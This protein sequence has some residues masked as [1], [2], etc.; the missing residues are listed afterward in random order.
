MDAMIGDILR[1]PALRPTP[2]TSR[3]ALPASVAST[4]VAPPVDAAQIDGAGLGAVAPTETVAPTEG[5]WAE[6]AS[7][8]LLASSAAVGG[9]LGGTLSAQ[10]RTDLGHLTQALVS[11][12]VTFFRERTLHLGNADRFEQADAAQVVQDAAEKGSRRLPLFAQSGDGMLIPVRDFDALRTLDAVAGTG[13]V[14]KL[15]HPAMASVLRNAEAVHFLVRDGREVPAWQAYQILS[16]AEPLAAGVT[17]S[18]DRAS[19]ALSS[20]ADLLVYAALEGVVEPHGLAREVREARDAGMSFLTR[21]REPEEMSA[22]DACG[23]LSRGRIAVG[24]VGVPLAECD[25]AGFAATRETLAPW[26][27]LYH[28]VLLPSGREDRTL[29][30]MVARLASSAPDR[31]DGDAKQMLS[32]ADAVQ[33]STPEYQFDE[34]LRD[35]LDWLAQRGPKLDRPE[36]QMPVVLRW[37]EACGARD[38]RQA[39]DFAWDTLSVAHPAP[40]DYAATLGQF[41]AL[42]SSL[43][44]VKAAQAALQV[45]S[46]P[47]GDASA[48][49]RLQAYERLLALHPPTDAG[50]FRSTENLRE[51]ADAAAADYLSVMASRSPLEG[52]VDQFERLHRALDT[53]KQADQTRTTFDFIE[54][55]LAGGTFGDASR[56]TVTTRFME[57]LAQTGDA[58]RARVLAMAPAGARGGTIERSD[59]TVVIGGIRVPRRM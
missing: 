27:K 35:T 58:E 59:D 52:A 39:A 20:E 33:K 54:N 8:G 13:D 21:H 56:E 16:G 3:P 46:V 23:A 6:C 41:D 47:L 45:V 30:T 31:L 12:G 34:A 15:A 22:F 14:T 4:S 55:G 57:A 40:A 48:Q 26:M 17:W 42:L 19:Q 51:R 11:R 50:R 25:G 9:P 53:C 29:R 38:A 18:G 5:F 10:A 44:D 1:A 49:G 43:R 37:I 7:L 36:T 24:I 28:D 32:V 2:L